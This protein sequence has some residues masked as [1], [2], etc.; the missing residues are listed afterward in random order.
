MSHDLVSDHYTVVCELLMSKPPPTTSTVRRRNIRGIDRTTFRA[1]ILDLVCQHSDITIEDLNCELRLLLDKHAPE[2]LRKL[3]HNHRDPW[4]TPAITV[5][6]RQKRQAERLWRSSGLTVHREIFVAKRNAEI[7]TVLHAKTQFYHQKITE[8]DTSKKLFSVTGDLLGKEK[9]SPLPNNIPHSDLP[10]TFSRYFSEKIQQIRRDLDSMSPAHVATTPPQIA[11]KLF[12][13]QPV[14]EDEVRKMIQKSAPKSCSLDPLPTTLLVEFVDDLIKPLTN[15]INQSLT[16][17]VFPEAFKTAIVKPL[18]KK[19][20]LDQNVLKNFRPV[21]NLS[22]VSKILEK[23][24]LK[25]L[26]VHLQSNGLVHPLQSAYRAGHSTETALT[27]VLNDLLTAYDNKHVSVLALLD[28]SAAFDT[29]DHQILLDRL[30]TFYGVSGRA[31]SWISSY[32]IGRRQTVVIDG[33]T[34]D[35]MLLECGVPQGSVLGPV[36]FTLYTQP[37][38]QV[39]SRHDMDH[40][41]YA[42]DTQVQAKT[43]PE[44]FDLAITSLQD[45]TSE[46][47]SWMTENK[48]KLN[49]DKTELMVVG[50]ELVPNLPHSVRIGQCDIQWSACARNLGVHLDKNLQMKEHVSITCKL[51]FM[52]IRRIGSIRHLLTDEA[53]CQLVVSLV[54]SR[55][56]YCNAL[57]AGL[58]DS[59][60]DRLQKV[61]NCAARLVTRSR[62][63]DHITPILMKLHWLPVKARIDYKLLTLCY[64]AVHF[65]SPSYLAE[66]L[67]LYAPSRALRSSRDTYRLVVPRFNCKTRG[68]RAFCF[69]APKKW[70][71]LSLE[72]RSLPSLANFKSALKTHLFRAYF[73]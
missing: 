42:D 47:Q 58:P 68:E 6:K 25:Q 3:S 28:L 39:F 27:K 18:L 51:C 69:L 40:H 63:H 19:P 61:Q 17:G 56:D 59:L 14:S 36:L 45:C 4:F 62:K 30:Q 34:S 44:N 52:E 49:N 29:I 13:F 24:A 72:M 71:D 35:P 37:L 32:L 60:I 53:T 12:E 5:A 21:S 8:S 41:M 26:N 15:I 55:L 7:Q 10:D 48:L 70:N 22:F 16:A 46:V 57:L 31:L 54:L 20:N 1:D 11:T 43:Q 50:S 67:R 2:T 23:I 73:K 66:V 38:S 9:V 33:L 65:G 64:K